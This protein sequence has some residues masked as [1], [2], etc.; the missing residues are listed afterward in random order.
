MTGASSHEGGGGVAGADVILIRHALPA[1][2]SG[3]PA[4][5]WLLGEGAEATCR[6]LAAD[7]DRQLEGTDRRVTRLWSSSEPKA[8]GTAEVL[9]AWW[10]LPDPTVHPG[11]DEHRRGPQPLVDDFA[12]RET[13]GRLFEQ[14]DELVLGEETASEA[15]ARFAAAMA[16]VAAAGEGGL[17]AVV[18]HATVMTL[19]LAAPNGLEPLQFWGSLRLPDAL[20]LSSSGWRLLGRAWPDTP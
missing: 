8:I 1:L 11:L 2:R 6:A 19:L 4:R 13:V 17:S 15:L 16:E 20:F 10:E 9:A 5:D 14:P 18:T 12:W 7:I 3:V